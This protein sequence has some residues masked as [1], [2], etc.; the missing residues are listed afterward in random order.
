MNSTEHH[1]FEPDYVS[2]PGASLRDR[3][4]ELNLSQTDLA[5]RAGFSAKHVNQIVQ[6]LAPIT[7]KRLSL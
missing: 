4:T 6:G 1:P 5:A 3:L 7:P 2:P